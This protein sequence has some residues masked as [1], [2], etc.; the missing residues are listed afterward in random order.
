MSATVEVVVQR[1]PDVLV[2]P[3]NASTQIDGKPTVFVKDGTGYRR[4]LIEVLAS[5][6]TDIVVASG[7]NEGDVIAMENP[8]LMAAKS[9]TL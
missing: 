5:N 1:L 6:G 8:E 3:A 2:I 7:L 9:R 4:V